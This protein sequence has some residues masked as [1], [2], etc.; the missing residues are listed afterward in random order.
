MDG[1]KRGH[2]K[3]MVGPKWKRGWMEVTTDW[4]QVQV[5]E[6][7]DWQMDA[8]IHTL[9]EQLEHDANEELDHM[10]RTEEHVRS[11]HQKRASH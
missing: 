4:M 10:A 9:Q 6:M 2:W 5:L 8:Q 11:L 1:W 3:Q 7:D